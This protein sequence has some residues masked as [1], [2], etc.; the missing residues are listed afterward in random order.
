MPKIEALTDIK[1]VK[2][3]HEAGGVIT[4]LGQNTFELKNSQVERLLKRLF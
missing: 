3:K 2:D 1:K 4:Q